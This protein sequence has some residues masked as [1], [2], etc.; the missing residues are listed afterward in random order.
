MGSQHQ[1]LLEAMVRLFELNFKFSLSLITKLRHVDRILIRFP[2]IF[3]V[4]VSL[5]CYCHSYQS[6]PLFMTF[7]RHF[8]P[9]LNAKH[10][11]KILED[12]LQLYIQHARSLSVLS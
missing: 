1:A 5:S 11:I 3:V 7:F 10:T 4:S 8:F 12:G 9:F 2:C 6:S